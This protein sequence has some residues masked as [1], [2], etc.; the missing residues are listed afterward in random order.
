MKS[1]AFMILV[2]IIGGTGFQVILETANVM[3]NKVAID[4]AIMNS[5]RAARNVALKDGISVGEDES[6]DDSIANKNAVIDEAVF[7]EEFAD[8]FAGTFDLEYTLTGA[9]EIVFTSSSANWN[10]MNVS[11][12]YAEVIINDRT[13]TDVTVNLSTP[14]KFQTGLL[15]TVGDAMESDFEITASHEF[16]IQIVN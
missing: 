10:G 16:R 1:I 14:Y 8:T 2:L 6:L 7:R 12:D 13:V 15:G 3:K 5:C 11:F 4:T 9:G